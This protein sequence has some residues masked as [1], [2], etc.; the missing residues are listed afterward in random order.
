M[1][2]R[3]ASENRCHQYSRGNFQYA[4]Y[5]N[6]VR[7]RELQYIAHMST[8]TRTRKSTPSAPVDAINRHLGTRVKNLRTARSWSLEA[9]A[10]ASGVSRSMLSQIERE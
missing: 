8:T 4:R 2:F 10:N 9:L 1:G 5:R 6:P 7:K 3:L